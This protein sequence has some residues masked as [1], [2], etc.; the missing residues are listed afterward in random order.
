[1]STNKVYGDRP[2][3]LEMIEGSQRWNL[4]PPREKG[5]D[6]TLGV[7]NC[8]HSLFGASKLAGDIVAQEYG[9]YFDMKVGI[10][11]GG[12]LTGPAHAGVELHGFLSYLI[13]CAVHQKPYTI[14]G[15]EGKQVRDQIHAYDVITAFDAFI[16]DPDPGAVYNIGGELANS[17]S[18]IESIKMIEA[19]ATAHIATTLSDNPRKGDHICYYTDMTK[20]RARYPEWKPS[21]TLLDIIE[22]MIDA[23][24]STE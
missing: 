20:F 3:D 16:N 1:M 21:Y 18:V 23:E 9:R 10:F 15:Y 13:K 17:A 24:R 12:C 14:F 7:D 19:C 11:R 4:A 22:E 6:E 8:M 5:I 2:N